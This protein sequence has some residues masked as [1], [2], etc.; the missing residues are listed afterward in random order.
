M[1]MSHLTDVHCRSFCFQVKGAKLDKFTSIA[2]TPT[3]DFAFQIE[4]YDGLTGV[5]GT[6]QI[7]MIKKEGDEWLCLHYTIM[8]SV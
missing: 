5:L 2:S 1:I 6:F 3:K 4:N 7:K 8:F